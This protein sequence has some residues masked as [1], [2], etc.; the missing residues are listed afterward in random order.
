ML[1]LW[2][3]YDKLFY[4]NRKHIY[5]K[6]YGTL[7]SLEGKSN[8]LGICFKDDTSYGLKIPVKINY[9]N[10]YEYQASKSKI[11]YCRIIRKMN[12]SRRRT[13]NYNTN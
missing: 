6:K 9:N 10:E 7:N 1:S 4:K 5:Y 2:K 3:A 13:N 8:K 12:S 11:F